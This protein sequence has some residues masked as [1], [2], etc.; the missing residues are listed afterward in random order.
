MRRFH[1]SER[2]CSFTGYRQSSFD[3]SKYSVAWIWQ[4]HSSAD[5]GLWMICISKIQT[6]N[7]SA[8]H[9]SALKEYL[10]ILHHAFRTKAQEL[11]FERNLEDICIQTLKCTTMEE[12]HRP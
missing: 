5:K 8:E 1:L 11:K 9:D 3:A 6:A 12:W 4:D 10:D 2:E 7:L